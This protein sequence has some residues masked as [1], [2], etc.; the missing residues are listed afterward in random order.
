MSERYS[1][2]DMDDVEPAMGAFRKMRIALDATGFGINHISLPANGSGPE[3]HEVETRHEEVYVTLDGSGVLELEG[4]R[5]EMRP[6]RWVRVDA[7]VTRKMT[8]GDEGLVFIAVGAPVQV[9]YRGR[10]TL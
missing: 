1:V 5:V 10:P 6:G 9:P 8:A 2:V 7:D 3:H 4:G